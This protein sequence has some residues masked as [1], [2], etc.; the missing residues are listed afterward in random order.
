M[1]R[2][3]ALFMALVFCLSMFSMTALAGESE[4]DSAAQEVQAEGES[5]GEEAQAEGESAGDS[6]AAADPTQ[7]IVLEEGEEAYENVNWAGEGGYLYV[8]GGSA[9][10]GGDE[11]NYELAGI[12]LPVTEEYYEGSAVDFD[13]AVNSVF[14]GTQDAAGGGNTFHVTGEGSSLVVKNIYATSQG[15]QTAVMYTDGS[16]DT[17]VIQDSYIESYGSVPG[18][19]EVSDFMALQGLLVWGHTRTNL[20]QGYTA[21]YYYNT[22]VIADGWAAMSTD[23]A[24]G[25]GVN[26]VAVNS[27]AETTDGGYA[28]YSDHECRDYIFGTTLVGAEYG[29]IIASGGELYMFDG[30]KVD[31]ETEELNA[32]RDA[33]LGEHPAELAETSIQDFANEHPVVAMEMYDGEGLEIGRSQ[34][35]GGRNCILVHKPDEAHQGK[36]ADQQN[37]FVAEG[38]DLIVDHTLFNTEDM[39]EGWYTPAD[40]TSSASFFNDDTLNYVEWT[41]GPAILIRSCSTLIYLDDVT[42]TSNWDE[43]EQK[44]QPDTFIMAVMNSDGNANLIADGDVAN[45]MDITIADS[46]ITGDIIDADYQREMLLTLDNATLN[47]KIDWFDC[48]MWNQVWGTEGFLGSG[49]YEYNES[50]ETVWGPVVTLVNGAVW[51]VTE[52]SYIKDYSVDE[53]SQIIGTI[54]AYEDGYK[55]YPEGTEA[56][57]ESAEGESEGESAEGESP[58]EEAVEAAGEGEY[59]LFD[60]Y[61]E[62]LVQTLLQDSFWSGKEDT[63]RND[64]AAA[65]TPDAESIQNFTGSGDVDQAPSGVTFPMTYDAWYAAQ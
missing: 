37:I 59:P 6:A 28:I 32:W 30:E 8:N 49:N 51:N 34:L 27:Y 62:Y 60:E 61:K 47:G 38:V 48:D 29:A 40:V 31:V 55:V 57:G 25:L 2:F 7:E 23:G 42:F 50:Y 11:D 63:L 35:I 20:S 58:A 17:M 54:E 16:D 14:T 1:K 10:V 15:S 45:P 33:F 26:F 18:Y 13:Y 4:G 46:E 64:L 56:A 41:S 9:V 43:V 52:E 44:G 5:A 12:I 53:T 21:T 3:L 36:G 39:P 65:D 22:A 19:E 24:Q